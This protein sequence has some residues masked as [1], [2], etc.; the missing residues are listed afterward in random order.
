MALAV[1][2]LIEKPLTAGGNV[3]AFQVAQAVA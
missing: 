1:L 3:W 2:G